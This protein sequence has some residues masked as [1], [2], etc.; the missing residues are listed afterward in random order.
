MELTVF[1]AVLFAALLH[2]GWNALVKFSDDRLLVLAIMK[3]GTTLFALAAVPFV[4]V[5]PIEAWPNILASTAIH[6]AYFIFLTIAYRLG[7]LG[8]IYPISRGTAPLIVAVL[9]AAFLDETLS[10]SASVALLLITAGIMSLAITRGDDGIGRPK[11][12]MAA[13]A[14]ACFTAGY[15]VVDGAGA[16]AT[17]DALSYIIWLNVVNGIPIIAIALVFRRAQLRNGVPRTW[18]FGS[19]SGIVSLLSY[20]IILWAGTQAPLALV[21]ALRESSMIF[22]LILG[23]VFLGEKIDLRRVASVFTTMAGTAMLKG[24]NG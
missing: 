5:P 11:A 16:R 4:D 10:G 22:A 20:W 24:S 21:A 23:V 19:I 6:T 17:G 9:A 2:A 8:Q 12:V 15:T 13:L 1:S 3:V 18:R 14:T 7:D